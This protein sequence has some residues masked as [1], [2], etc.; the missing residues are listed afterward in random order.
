MKDPTNSHKE[1]YDWVDALENLNFSL[2][3]KDASLLIQEFVKY[4]Q[5]KGVLD[6]KIFQLPFENSIS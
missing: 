3:E 4:A 1:L 5:N 6:D 2:M